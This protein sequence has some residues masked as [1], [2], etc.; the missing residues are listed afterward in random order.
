MVCIAILVSSKFTAELIL[1][2]LVREIFE[3]KSEHAR[4]VLSIVIVCVC[5]P[6]LGSSMTSDRSQYLA[7]KYFV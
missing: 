7:I 3:Q 4:G 1:V 5:A 6:W 2:C